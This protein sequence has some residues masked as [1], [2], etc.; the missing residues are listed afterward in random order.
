VLYYWPS[1]EIITDVFRLPYRAD[2]RHPEG[3]ALDFIMT[4][5]EHV[6]CKDTDVEKSPI[7]EAWVMACAASGLLP[8]ALLTIV[9]G[10]R[11][12]RLRQLL[13]SEEPFSDCPKTH[14]AVRTMLST[15]RQQWTI[16][17]RAEKEANTALP[18]TAPQT[19]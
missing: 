4:L 7:L 16:Q 12:R 17:Y 1:Y 6:W 2:R 13:Q 14:A 11:I 10:R 5:F 9:K 18:D 3:P 15:L 8:K 19:S